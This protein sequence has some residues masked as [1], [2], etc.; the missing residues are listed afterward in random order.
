MKQYL[1]SR[2]WVLI[3]AGIVFGITFIPY[4]LGFAIQGEDWRFSGFV[5]GVEDGNSYIAKM[6]NGAN[7]DWLFRTPYT[8]LKQPGIL[9]FIPYLLLG[10]LS[11]G[12]GQHEQL[13]ALF[14][15]FRGL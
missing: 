10:K 14:Q 11:A 4:L 15:G 12:L 3:W 9:A 2:K 8:T 6:I 7:G 5:F 1:Q 13:L